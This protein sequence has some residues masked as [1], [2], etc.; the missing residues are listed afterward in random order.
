[1]LKRWRQLPQAGVGLLGLAL[2]LTFT[3]NADAAGHSFSH[4]TMMAGGTEAEVN[5][6]VSSP[7]ATPPAIQEFS[8]AGSGTLLLVAGAPTCAAVG[9]I[10]NT[11]DNCQ[12]ATITGNV[13]DGVGP[14]FQGTFVLYLNIVSN[15]SKSV[16]DGNN[17][18]QKCFFAT[19]LLSESPGS[20]ATINFNTA[21]LT[22]NGIDNASLLYSGGFTIGDTSTGGFA[23]AVGSGIIGVGANRS[24]LVGAF[25]LK[26]AA[27][28]I[29]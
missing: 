29:N 14:L 22:C 28:D 10:C 12:C 24:T 23:G 17:V 13:T 18:G 20:G 25:D 21:G 3:L 19:G 6:S 5:A 26:G 9:L 11:G 1:M 27:A 4:E 16:D 15:S 8:S 2:L 7:A